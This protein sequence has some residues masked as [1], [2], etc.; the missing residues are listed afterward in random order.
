MI[1]YIRFTL[2]TADYKGNDIADLRGVIMQACKTWGLAYSERT[3]REGVRYIVAEIGNI[4][5]L[6][7]AQRA[8]FSGSL[9]KYYHRQPFSFNRASFIDCISEL[10]EILGLPFALFAGARVQRMELHRDIRLMGYTAGEAINAIKGVK[11][12]KCPLHDGRGYKLFRGERWRG[13]GKASKCIKFY[14][15][16]KE[17]REQQGVNLGY[18]LLRIEMELNKG[19]LPSRGVRCISDLCTASTWER[20][21]QL[22]TEEIQG[23]TMN[24]TI[25]TQA[26][27]TAL[28]CGKMEELI[29]YKGLEGLGGLNSVIEKAK[30]AHQEG[31]ITAY[32]Y[33]YIRRKYTSLCNEIEGILPPNEMETQIKGQSDHASDRPNS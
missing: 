28:E 11:G 24:I 10:A 16:A 8:V 7:F 19:V 30:Q 33:R 27:I 2:Q 14:D 3:S 20:L 9:S 25:D 29:K 15:K 18:E 6:A 4:Q 12:Y 21:H 32:Q 23:I 22:L 31:K 13:K 17:L 26:I 5:V 1:D